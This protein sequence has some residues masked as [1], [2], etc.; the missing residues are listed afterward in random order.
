MTFEHIQVNTEPNASWDCVG[1]LAP[2][3]AVTCVVRLDGSIG[4]V[5]HGRTGPSLSAAITARPRRRVDELVTANATESS[6]T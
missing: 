2:V 6:P 3:A 4:A 1:P 5:G